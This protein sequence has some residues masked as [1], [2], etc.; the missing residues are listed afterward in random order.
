MLGP[1]PASATG[2]LDRGGNRRGPIEFHGLPRLTTRPPLPVPLASQ[3]VPGS[4]TSALST[5]AQSVALERRLIRPGE[6]LYA[7]GLPFSRLHVVNAGCLKLVTREADGRERVTKF[8]FKGDWMGLDALVGRH[9]SC[10]AVCMDTAE[11]WSFSYAQL[12]QACERNPALLDVMLRTVA[13][14]LAADS[15][16]MM[17]LCTLPTSARV[18]QFL[19]HWVEAMASRQLRI[20]Q[21]TLRLSREE[22]GSHLGM[23]LESVSRSLSLLEKRGLI[24]FIGKGRREICIPDV[25]A[26]VS[27]IQSRKAA[28]TCA[29]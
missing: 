12:L 23:T 9:Y 24:G 19:C 14:D 25:A 7:Q 2:A 1:V 8:R 29:G 11:V 26:L 20:D 4:A 15:E 10:D 21:I 5:I 22:I 16:Q 28:D 13:S 27:F 3:A 17:T 18:A 6:V